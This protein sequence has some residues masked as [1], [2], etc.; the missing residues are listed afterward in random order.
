MKLRQKKACYLLGALSIVFLFVGYFDIKFLL[1]EHINLTACNSLNYTT[2]IRDEKTAIKMNLH[3]PT[4][5]N[6]LCCIYARKDS[7]GLSLL[8]SL[9]EIDSSF[10]FANLDSSYSF[11]KKALSIIPNDQCF[12]L[13]CALLAAIKGDLDTSTGYLEP[14]I[15]DESA[16]SLILC[17]MGLLDER[18]GMP[19]EARSVYSRAIMRDPSIV[20]S[21]FFKELFQRNSV[22]SYQVVD[23]ATN[24]LE[25]RYK[26]T[27]DPIVAAKLGKL[28]IERK[29][30][31]NARNMLNSALNALPTL[32]RPW[33]N[34]GL[35]EQMEGNDELAQDYFIRSLS[36]DSYDLLPLEKLSIY[37]ESL[38]D[39]VEYIRRNKTS[40]HSY[41]LKKMYGG[42]SLK[43]PYVIEGLEQYFNLF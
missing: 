25:S 23:I 21:L 39:Q 16:S 8:N 36:L 33:Y 37:D 10:I 9:F 2:G 3:N 30:Y 32:G 24:E 7:L 20:E 31:D 29:D 19:N 12:A 17:V 11:S 5:I 34:L 41:R 18:L 26:T 1:A 13:N 42:M 6:N 4:Y 35:I 43:D 28:L 27:N 40:H 22:I 14:F 38:V 15:V